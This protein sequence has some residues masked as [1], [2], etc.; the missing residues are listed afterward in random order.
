MFRRKVSASTRMNY[1]DW[2]DVVACRFPC[3]WTATEN[4]S[5][6]SAVRG[7]VYTLRRLNNDRWGFSRLSNIAHMQKDTA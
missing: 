6:E 2:L 4:D 3:D 7:S 1:A 5:Y